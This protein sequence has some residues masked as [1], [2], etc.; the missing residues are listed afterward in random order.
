MTV[1]KTPS[2][3]N[4]IVRIYEIPCVHNGKAIE[5]FTVSLSMPEAEARKVNPD[6]DEAHDE[7]WKR[8]ERIM[9]RDKREGEPVGITF[10]RE[11]F[12]PA[13]KATQPGSAV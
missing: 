3:T 5:S 1:T 13:A 11:R 4:V 10:V 9:K 12:Y 2:T 6:S 8:A 7:A